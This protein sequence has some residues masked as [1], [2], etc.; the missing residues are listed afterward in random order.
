MERCSFVGLVKYLAIGESAARAIRV[1][2]S[3]PNAEVEMRDAIVQLQTST[4]AMVS[5][6]RTK[7]GSEFRVDTGS[8]VTNDKSAVIANVCVTRITDEADI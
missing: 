6:L 4:N 8:Y 7:T 3:S 5:R 1:P 2:I